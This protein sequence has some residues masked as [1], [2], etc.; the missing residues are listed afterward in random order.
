MAANSFWSI[1]EE[2]HTLQWCVIP[3]MKSL[4]KTTR[5]KENL[6][7]SVQWLVRYGGQSA[8][9]SGYSLVELCVHIFAHKSG[10]MIYRRLWS[11]ARFFEIY[12]RIHLHIHW[13][14]RWRH[15]AA[16]MEFGVSRTLFDHK[17]FSDIRN[18]YFCHYHSLSKKQGYDLIRASARCDSWIKSYG[19]LKTRKNNIPEIR[20]TY[21]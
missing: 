16:I 10:G 6:C 18:H 3:Q 20:R 8:L 19:I 21:F 15:W 5:K 2:V 13:H 11:K 9:K 7:K 14:C 17:C 4:D 1:F 12:R